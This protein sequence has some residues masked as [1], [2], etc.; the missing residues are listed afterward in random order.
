ML[1]P[2]WAYTG[3]VTNDRGAQI[4]LSILSRDQSLRQFN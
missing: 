4:S 1:G 3:P 2:G